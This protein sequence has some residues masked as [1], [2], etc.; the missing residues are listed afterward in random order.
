M[1]LIEYG[2]PDEIEIKI[3]KLLIEY[4]DLKESN[5]LAFFT[6]QLLSAV[7]FKKEDYQKQCKYIKRQLKVA[8]KFSKTYMIIPSHNINCDSSTSIA[9]FFENQT[10]DENCF[11]ID[12]KIW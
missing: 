8:D 7:Y 4:S 5:R 3:E 12:P 6:N 1:E 10:M 9:W 11:W 2:E